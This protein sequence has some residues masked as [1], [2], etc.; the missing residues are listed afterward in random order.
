MKIV[1]INIL[2]LLINWEKNLL[3]SFLQVQGLQHKSFSERRSNTLYHGQLPGDPVK[4]KGYEQTT[5]I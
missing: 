1:I 3:Q 2:N 5:S 4:K